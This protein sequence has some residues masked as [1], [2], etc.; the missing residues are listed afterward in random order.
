MA[1]EATN[2]VRENILNLKSLALTSCAGLPNGT[3]RLSLIDPDKTPF[4]LLDDS[5]A[6]FTVSKGHGTAMTVEKGTDTFEVSAAYKSKK[7]YVLYS[8]QPNTCDHSASPLVIDTHAETDSPA[9]IELSAPLDGILFDILGRNARPVA[10]AK[11]QISW[12][13]NPDRYKFLVLVPANG[14]V[15]GI[16]QMF[17]DNTFG[18]D[19]KNPFAANGSPP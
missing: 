5:A 15:Q 1:C 13:R 6:A 4:N 16:D 14:I 12:V 8:D 18:P 11:K 2:G 10:H 9:G 19:K 3:Y 7:L 17:G